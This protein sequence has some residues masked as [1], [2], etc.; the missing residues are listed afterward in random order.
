MTTHTIEL[1]AA[2][3]ITIRDL[4]LRGNVIANLASGVVQAI[5]WHDYEVQCYTIYQN[6][7]YV[8]ETRGLDSDGWAS[9]EDIEEG[10]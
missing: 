9:S 4:A 5:I 10:N 3:D 6:G 8:L 1:T 7:G 2:Q